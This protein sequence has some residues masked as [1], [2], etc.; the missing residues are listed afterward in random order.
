VNKFL[1]L[2]KGFSTTRV[3]VHCLVRSIH[4]SQEI[5][6]SDFILALLVLFY[7]CEIFAV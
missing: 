2:F 7:V 5:V 4:T 3:I 6:I 1:C